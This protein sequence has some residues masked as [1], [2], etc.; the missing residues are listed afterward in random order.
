MRTFIFYGKI[1]NHD[2]FNHKIPWQKLGQIVRN[3]FT[4]KIY[5]KCHDKTP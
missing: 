1:E 5:A 2:K 4:T 3:E